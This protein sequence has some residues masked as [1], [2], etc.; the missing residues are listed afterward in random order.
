MVLEALFVSRICR[1]IGYLYRF[2]SI[3]VTD[4]RRYKA[5]SLA[6]DKMNP[7]RDNVA[8]ETQPIAFNVAPLRRCALEN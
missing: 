3:T 5:R 2:V 4:T 6:G 8:M 7:Q 1:Q